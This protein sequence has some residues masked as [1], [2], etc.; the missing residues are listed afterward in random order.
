MCMWA[1]LASNCLCMSCRRPSS[2]PA[3][4]NCQRCWLWRKSVR[5]HLR[6]HSKC[7]VKM[8]TGKHV[9]HAESNQVPTWAPW[10]RPET[11]METGMFM[12]FM[13]LLHLAGF[14]Q[15]LDYATGTNVLV[16]QKERFLCWLQVFDEDIFTFKHNNLQ[17][18]DFLFSS[19]IY[20]LEARLFCIK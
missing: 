9:H 2:R 8:M 11:S 18:N 17:L 10:S 3:V 13:V 6:H 16:G 19:F 7:S 14:N 4:L 1:L 15:P 12:F 20:C 5:A